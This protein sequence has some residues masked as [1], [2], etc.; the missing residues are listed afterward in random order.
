M[1]IPYP[2]APAPD[3]AIYIY[4]C[5]HACGGR[6]AHI[7]QLADGRREEERDGCRDKH[8]RHLFYIYIYMSKMGVVTSTVVTYIY[9]Y[10]DREIDVGR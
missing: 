8:G 7:E 2:G 10:T 5:M 9:I 3:K 1:Y 6:G 4:E